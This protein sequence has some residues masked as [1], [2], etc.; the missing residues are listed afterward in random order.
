MSESARYKVLSHTE[1]C[2]F[3][4]SLIRRLAPDATGEIVGTVVDQTGA[5]V[6]GATVVV[7]NTATG[8]ARS[9]TTMHPAY[10]MRLL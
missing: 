10:T 5:V 8:V 9:L 7:T 4:A 6:A 1:S 3:S 2:L